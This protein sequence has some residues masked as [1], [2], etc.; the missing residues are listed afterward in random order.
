M[1]INKNIILIILVILFLIIIGNYSF[2]LYYRYRRNL[3]FNEIVNKNFVEIKN[4]KTDIYAKS[5]LSI[6]WQ[7]GMVDIILFDNRLLILF[8]NYFLNK[9]INMN[10]AV[11]QISKNE[12]TRK[13]EG[14]SKLYI[15]QK[16]EN[17]GTKLKIYTKQIFILKSYLE[18]DIDFKDKLEELKI[19]TKFINEELN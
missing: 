16:N 10:L 12:N 19:V 9:F 7:L 18:I 14:V 4:L 6:S 3:V 8:K 2:Y 13:L 15:F 5:K 11:I 1:Q 17:I